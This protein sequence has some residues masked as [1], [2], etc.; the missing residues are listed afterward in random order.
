MR[1]NGIRSCN[2]IA[3]QFLHGDESQAFVSEVEMILSAENV[4]IWK[5]YGVASGA[6]KR[7]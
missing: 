6:E 4:E 5:A 7:R 1:K 3:V 2:F